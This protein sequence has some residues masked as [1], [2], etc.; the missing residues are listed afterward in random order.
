MTAT[1]GE[2]CAAGT[3]RRSRDSVLLGGLSRNSGR[4]TH[5]WPA[6]VATYGCR[7]D[8]GPLGRDQVVT[9]QCEAQRLRATERCHPIPNRMVAYLVGGKGTRTGL[10]SSSQ[11]TRTSPAIGC[12]IDPRMMN[13]SV[14]ARGCRCTPLGSPCAMPFA[15]SSTVT[16]RFVAVVTP[17]F[18]SLYEWPATNSAL[19]VGGVGAA[20]GGAWPP[21]VICPCAAASA[22]VRSRSLA[23]AS[24]MRS[25]DSSTLAV[26]ALAASALRP[27]HHEWPPATTEIPIATQAGTSPHSMAQESA[28]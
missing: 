6:D 26:P 27:V 7:A 9:S 18:R 11:V 23:S 10:G 1:H 25:R 4:V 24:A 3:H 19:N 13:G 5:G 15:K 28:A 16:A 17:T 2:A 12:P 8:A 21:M 22:V 14:D 20:V